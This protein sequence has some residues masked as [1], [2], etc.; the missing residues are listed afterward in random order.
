VI[1]VGVHVFIVIAVGEYIWIVTVV[2]VYVLS[3]DSA[4]SI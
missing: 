3:F 1:V 2:S 4:K